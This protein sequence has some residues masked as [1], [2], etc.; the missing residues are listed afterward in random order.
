MAAPKEAAEAVVLFED[1]ERALGLERFT[2]RHLPSWLGM[3]VRAAW[4]WAMNALET[5]IWRLPWAR[6][7]NDFCT[8][9]SQPEH[10]YIVMFDA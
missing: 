6:V 7:H 5:C 4:R 1:A 8:Q 9:A 3:R 2:R 10:S